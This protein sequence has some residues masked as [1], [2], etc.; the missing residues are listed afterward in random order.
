MRFHI[1]E[2]KDL[3]YED[4]LMADQSRIGGQNGGQILAERPEWG[5]QNRPILACYSG[6]SPNQGVAVP[7]NERAGRI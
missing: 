2:G 1:E 5:G 7:R 3:A 6:L 4:N